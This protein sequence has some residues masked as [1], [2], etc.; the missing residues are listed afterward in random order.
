MPELDYK[1]YTYIGNEY[2]VF[3]VT[4]ECFFDFALA[5]IDDNAR[6]RL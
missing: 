5:L 1:S 3:A 4:D 6:T 2:Q